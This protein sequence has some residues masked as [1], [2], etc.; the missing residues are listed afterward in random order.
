MPTDPIPSAL[1]ARWRAMWHPDA[2]LPRPWWRFSSEAPRRLERVDGWCVHDTFT[3]VAI[4]PSGRGP[5]EDL[6]AG[7]SLADAMAY[8]DT[9]HP[10]PAPDPMPGQV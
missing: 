10:I 4:R 5:I 7:T 1:A 6:P 9:N 3:G 2:F 8:V